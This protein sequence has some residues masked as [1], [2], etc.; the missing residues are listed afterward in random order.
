MKNF[1][2]YNKYNIIMYLIAIINIIVNIDI[3]IDVNRF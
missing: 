3:L 1:R 2:Y